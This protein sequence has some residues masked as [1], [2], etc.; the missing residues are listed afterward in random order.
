[1]EN[2]YQA[3]F[4]E[5]KN[6]DSPDTIDLHEQSKETAIKYL[7][8]KVMTCFN[9]YDKLRVIVGLGNHNDDGRSVLGPAVR[10]WLRTNGYDF[11][12]EKGNPGCIIVFLD[13]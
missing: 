7:E 3:I 10:E 2:H 6:E 9:E 4:D 8:K 11:Q 1:M 13:D 5:Y 12:D